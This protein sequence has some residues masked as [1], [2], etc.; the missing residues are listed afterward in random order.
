MSLISKK[1]LGMAIKR[2][3]GVFDRKIKESK[4]KATWNQIDSS[5]D[6]YVKNRTHWEEEK[7]VS[8]IENYTNAD[9][10]DGNIPECNFTPGVAYNVTWN[11]V[12]YEDLVCYFDGSYNIIADE[13][14]GCPFYIDDDG[15][16][17]LYIG[18]DTDEWTVSIFEKQTVIH[19]ID[20]KYLP[21]GIGGQPSIQ[22]D[23][24]Q[25]D[26]T[27]PDYVKNKPFGAEMIL[28]AVQEETFITLDDT[29]HG[30]YDGTWYPNEGVLYTVTWDGVQY[31]GV[32]YNNSDECG[33][34]D[35]VIDG[36]TL[37]FYESGAIIATS[38]FAGDHTFTIY[39][40]TENVKK[41]D[42]KYLPDAVSEA[43]NK[44]DKQDPFGYGSFSM[45][46]NRGVSVGEY[47]STLGKDCSAEGD[48]AVSMGRLSVADGES[49][50]AI[51]SVAEAYGDYSVAIGR[52][53]TTRGEHSYVIGKYNNEYNDDNRYCLVVGNGVS[54]KWSDAH[55]L[56][57]EGNAWYSGDVY[58][59]SAS[60][61]HHDE[62]SKKLATEEYVPNAASVDGSTLKM[63]RKTTA[64]DG[65]ETTSE[66]FEVELPSGGM[67]ISL[68]VTG[69]A[70]GQIPTIMA[71]D[72]SG[73]PT[74]WGAVDLPSGGGV[75][76]EI[77]V[78]RVV[79]T[80]EVNKIELAVPYKKTPFKA[81]L[82][83][84]IHPSASNTEESRKSIAFY[85]TGQNVFARDLDIVPTEDI[86]SSI[87]RAGRLMYAF[88]VSENLTLAQ[89]SI[90]TCG[91]Y[92]NAS[93]A[94][95]AQFSYNPDG[96]EFKIDTNVWENAKFGIG[97]VFELRVI[98]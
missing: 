54:N 94:N 83:V 31:E 33:I 28:D 96:G 59:G 85:F 51:G 22:P 68:G 86:K 88:N 92:H 13:S 16:N 80:E 11:G 42:E 56:D 49:S 74:E 53:V 77:N 30:Y 66:L 44:M 1:Q 38:N 75:S 2:L 63:Q 5:A 97:S 9:Y 35:V 19:Q 48:Y 58:V 12:L 46:R 43:V 3:I 91:N 84:D 14:L 81:I 90:A 93:N 57:W 36:E 29:G 25:N 52:Y 24:N 89:S 72:D 7:I 65:T 4:T 45:N 20:K 61:T 82:Y 67:D 23:W 69:A 39:E 60:G 50:C 37:R 62:G 71:V 8:I 18:F 76:G 6:D 17:G 40:M 78:E 27:Q 95:W 73:K 70:V 15:G 55:T 64:D 41:L 47:S 26:E 79:L 98:E 34:L 10:S 32:A 87:P 21:D